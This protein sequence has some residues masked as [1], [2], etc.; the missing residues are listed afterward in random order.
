[1]ILDGETLALSP[2]VYE[3]VEAAPAG[4]PGELKTEFHASVV[5]LT[6]G[7]SA[8]AAEAGEALRVLRRAAADTAAGLG[9]RLAAAGSHPFSPPA[10]QTIAREE[11]YAAFVEY[12]GMTARRQGVSGLHVHVGMPD[13]ETSY[14]VLEAL[15]PLLPV[16][17]ALSANSPY[18]DGAETGLLSTRAEVLATLPRSGAPP[19]FGS[20]AGWVAFVERLQAAGVPLLDDY[21]NFWWDIRPHPMYGTLEIRMPDQPTSVAQT[22][23]LADLLQRLCRKLA[24]DEA[25]PVDPARRADYAQNRWAAARFGPSAALIHPDGDRVVSAREL[26]GELL[27]RVGAVQG[28]ELESCEAERQLEVGRERGLEAVCADLAERTLA[29]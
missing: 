11:R 16:V 17:L 18:L 29:W 20:Y 2:S 15:L 8:N 22:V 14:R 10:E 7:I 21:R 28:L 26:A 4:L 27:D 12:V 9:L 3:L 24:E 19:A 5:E 6:G 23:A 25:R 13:G 1:M